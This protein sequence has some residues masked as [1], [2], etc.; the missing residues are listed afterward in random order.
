VVKNSRQRLGAWGEGV[1]AQYLSERGYTILGRNIR[2]PYGEIDIV[3]RQEED[4]IL[5]TGS[6]C[7][8]K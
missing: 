3:A 7:L 5:S 6:L 2:T 4:R 1:A 8:W